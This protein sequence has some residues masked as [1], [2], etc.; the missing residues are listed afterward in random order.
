[1]TR[2]RERTRDGIIRLHTD[3]TPPSA[4]YLADMAALKAKEA[5]NKA[6][7]RVEMRRL[8]HEL[9]RIQRLR[10]VSSDSSWEEP[11]SEPPSPVK[12]K[13]MKAMKA[14]A[15]KTMQAKA[16]AMKAMKAK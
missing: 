16:K 15:M 1:M 2:T 11:P 9:R 8:N 14:K 12:K 13:A 10:N 4:A 7:H 6:Y 3:G 5:H